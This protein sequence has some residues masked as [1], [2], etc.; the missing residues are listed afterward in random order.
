MDIADLTYRSTIIAILRLV[1]VINESPH[2]ITCKNGPFSF[3]VS[4][5]LF[6]L[7]TY[8]PSKTAQANPAGH[9]WSLRSKFSLPVSRLWHHS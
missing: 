8:T 7:L 6:L 4:R 3:G 5:H 2:D 1:V 9:L